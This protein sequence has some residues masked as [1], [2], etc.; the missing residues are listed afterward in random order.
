MSVQRLRQIL[1]SDFTAVIDSSQ[2]TVDKV[3]QLANARWQSLIDAGKTPPR[4]KEPQAVATLANTRLMT[5]RAIDVLRKTGEL[6][7]AKLFA[8]DA[9]ARDENMNFAARHALRMERAP[10]VLSELKAQIEAASRTA[11]PSSPLGKASSY[12]L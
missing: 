10:S 12:T 6:Q 4:A 3:L 7:M 2:A 11:L 8:I 5:F 1:G 9:Q